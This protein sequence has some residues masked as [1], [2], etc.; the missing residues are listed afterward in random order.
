MEDNDIVEL[1]LARNEEAIS[2]T[3]EKYGSRIKQIAFGILSNHESAEECENDTYHKAWESI[4][5]NEPRK[6]LFAYLG[7][8][9]RNIALNRLKA[10]TRK[11]RSA[12]CVELTQ[13]MMESI[14]SGVNVEADMLYEELKQHIEA[15][16]DTCS[17]IQQ[18]IFVRR[19]WYFDSVAE[20]SQRY[21]Y[22][23][24]KVKTVLFRMREGLKQ[25]LE[26]E[27]YTV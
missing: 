2:R 12:G 15:Y 11:K 3:A 18:K 22:S 9:V 24:S 19:Y 7:R 8:I 16:L 25:L 5:P 17:E 21:G 14:P 6:H 23:Q 1:F 27:G 4:P 13:E 26:K 10:D 20:I